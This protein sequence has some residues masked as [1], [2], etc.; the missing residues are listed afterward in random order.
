MERDSLLATA[1]PLQHSVALRLTVVDVVERVA[2]VVLVN[3]D[4]DVYRV[5][6][7]NTLYWWALHALAQ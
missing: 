5:M 4:V 1:A 6:K 2:Q 7:D 3:F